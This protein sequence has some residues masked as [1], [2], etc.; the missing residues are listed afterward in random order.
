MSA[1]SPQ[2]R[3]VAI[4]DS[5]VGKTAIINRLMADIF[6]PEQPTT[7]GAEW[8]LF[9]H[10]IGNELV[11]FQI[12]DTAGQEKYRS[13]GPLYYRNA[14]G[15]VLVFDVTDRSSFGNLPGWVSAFTTVAGTEVVI[16]AAANK[17]DLEDKRQVSSKE[18]FDWATSQKF[19]LYETSAKSGQGITA[20]FNALAEE[21][22]KVKWRRSSG[23]SGLPE[24]SSSTRKCC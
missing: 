11:Q 7:I 12:W 4:G 8:Q 2:G 16:I 10:N 24:R 15:A 14:I 9:S 1:T 3:V 6:D 22:L 20:L 5:S 23:R 21:V 18:A 19:P 17:C 13:L